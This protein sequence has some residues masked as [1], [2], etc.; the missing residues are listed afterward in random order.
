[1]ARAKNVKKQPVIAFLQAFSDS[2]L[3]PRIE[4]I[5]AQTGLSPINLLQ[6]WTLQEESLVGLMQRASAQ[7]PE[8][9]KTRAA[10][11]AR[12]NVGRKKVVSGKNEKKKPAARKHKNPD[13]RGTLLGR[14]QQ[15][16]QEGVT[17]QKIA[18]TFNNE[19]MATLSGTGKWFASSIKH[20]LNAKKD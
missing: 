4:K 13:Y 1:M 16:R 20:L 19:K 18:E 6:K 9:V 11:T 2:D 15:L 8:P 14:V 12:A 17:L 7:R 5:S 10:R 3:P